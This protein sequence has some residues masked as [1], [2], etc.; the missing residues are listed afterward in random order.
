M[1]NNAEIS[2]IHNPEFFKLLISKG[3]LTEKDSQNLLNKFKGDAFSVLIYLV[4]GS[5]SKKDDLC[6]LWGDT[7]GVAYVNLDKT[8]FQ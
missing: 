8:L 3:I 4:K 6:K 1:N 2:K 5:V 7:L